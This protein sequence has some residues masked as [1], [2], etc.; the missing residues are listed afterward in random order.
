[1][2]PRNLIV[3]EIQQNQLQTAL[4]TSTALI[5]FFHEFSLKEPVSFSLQQRVSQVNNINEHLTLEVLNL[6]VRPLTTN[7]LSKRKPK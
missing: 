7:N 5:S 1:M 2:Q 3:N 6:P 4:K